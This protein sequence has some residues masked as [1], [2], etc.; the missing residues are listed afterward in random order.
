VDKDQYT[1]LDQHGS[2]R[3]I[4]TQEITQKRDTKRAV[5]LDANQNTIQVGDLVEVISGPN[6]VRIYQFLNNC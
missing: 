4:R 5:S 1:I 6:T 2:S 3:T